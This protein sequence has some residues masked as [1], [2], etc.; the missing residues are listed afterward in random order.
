MFIKLAESFA[1]VQFEGKWVKFIFWGASV[2]SISSFILK[3]DIPLFTIK[4]LLR[5]CII[6]KSTL[7]PFS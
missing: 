6:D 4:I 2:I 7:L 3:V 1:K 5:V